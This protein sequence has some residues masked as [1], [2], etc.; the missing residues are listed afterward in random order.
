MRRD[1]LAGDY[2]STNK[3]EEGDGERGSR[4][5]LDWIGGFCATLAGEGQRIFQR[6]PVRCSTEWTYVIYHWIYQSEWSNCLV[7]SD[8]DLHPQQWL[9]KDVAS[10]N[11]PVRLTFFRPL[12]CTFNYS[13]I[14]DY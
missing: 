2:K 6:L 9:E 8:Y 3:A 1:G 12:L 4:A 7:T 14:M 10:Q 13:T 5:V 11:A